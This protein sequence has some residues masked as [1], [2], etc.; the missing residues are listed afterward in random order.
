MNNPPNWIDVLLEFL[1]KDRFIDEVVGDLHEWYYWKQTSFT[2]ARLKR[3]YLWNALRVLRLH[4]IKK[5]KFL[6]LQIIDQTMF[7]NN[8]KI[9]IRSLVQHRFFTLLNVV[10]LTLSLVSFILIYSYVIFEYSYNTFH[11]KQ[12]EVYR[13]LRKNLNSGERERPMPS[14]LANA[15]LRDF[16]G[17]MEFARFG[18]DPVFVRLESKQFY[19][20]NFY[21]SDASVFRVFDLPFV[22]GNAKAALRDKNT[23]V[24]T[25]TISEKYFGAG[26]NPVGKVLPIKIYDGNVA[27]Q[28][29]IDGVI[30]DLPG[31]SD[32]PFRLLG[33]M[34]SADELYSHFSDQWWLHWQHAYVHVPDKND[35]IRIEANVPLIVA[36]ELG[37]EMAAQMTFEFQPLKEVHLFSEGVAGSLTSGSIQQVTILSVIG[38]FILLIASINYL[39]LISARINRRKKEVGIRRVMGAKSAQI[40]GQFI[41]ESTLIVLLSFLISTIMV[42]TIWPIFN[43]LLD[44]PIPGSLMVSWDTVTHLGLALLCVVIFSSV[45]P[46]WLAASH[47]TKALADKH[48]TVQSKRL[49]QKG[50]VTFQFAIT[51]FLVVSSVL[52]FRQVSFMTQTDL[53]FDKSHLVTVK[54]EDKALQQ[55]INVIRSAML[56]IPNVNQATATGESLPSAMNNGAEMH[57]GTSGD[58]H[59]FVNIVAIDEYF[60]ETLGITLT[61]G[62]SFTNTSDASLAGPVILNEAA[63]QLLEMDAIGT[64]IELLDQ[65]RAIIGVVE[66]Y[67]YE[68]LKN[69]VQPVVFVYGAPGYR[70]SP[71]NLI[72]RLSG[73]EVA[74]T[75]D[76]LESVWNA[77]SSDELF[78]Y[79]FVD[80]TYAQLYHNDRRFLK[81]FSMFSFLS[82][83]VS[84]LGLY[85]VVL[86]ATDER[87]KEISIRKVLGSSV[88]QVTTL[89]SKKFVILIGLGL[90]LGLPTALYFIDG[91]LVQFSYRLA[92]EPTYIL[93]ALLLV[94][95]TAGLTI[96]TNTLKAALAN[97]VKYLRNE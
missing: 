8:L 7:S 73:N 6:L 1:L 19:E 39:N 33:T 25:Q 11:P 77:F 40:M 51:V 56:E 55:K 4:Q 62:Q 17:S 61:A 50:L 70:E 10:G 67:H 3:V 38:L 95:F 48:T 72:L 23:V 18:Q 74:N 13:V 54:V 94:F 57:W 43:E 63:A 36:R 68:S 28:M 37:D 15:F 71:D 90:L 24:L 83:V 89:V 49:L 75:M 86:F 26:V 91:W 97:P 12:E 52:I 66:N 92:P 65:Q 84:C 59:H 9:G 82:I 60:F 69:K 2:S 58:G 21:W 44:K 47:R 88:M 96:G 80:D 32:L 45:H 20:P 35:L 14:P 53:G 87:S 93:L 79:H 78:D 31:N 30:A 81:L 27:L 42:W 29:R 5:V 64:S 22:Y 76:E 85:G 41:T 46:A 34:K 16:E